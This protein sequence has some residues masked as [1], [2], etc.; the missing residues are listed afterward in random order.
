MAAVIHELWMGND[1]S[2]L[3][4]PGLSP[5]RAQRPG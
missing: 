3:I 5:K 2:L 4:M 1:A